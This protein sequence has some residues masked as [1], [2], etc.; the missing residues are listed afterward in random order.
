MSQ[1]NGSEKPCPGISIDTILRLFGRRGNKVW[2]VAALS[3]QPWM[4]V[5]LKIQQISL[6][7]IS[8][9][10]IPNSTALYINT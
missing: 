10:L 9:E 7:I 2:K 8:S 4:A 5:E 6:W 1:G 3:N